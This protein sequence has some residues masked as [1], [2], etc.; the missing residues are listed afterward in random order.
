MLTAAARV[1]ETFPPEPTKP[2][3]SL[4]EKLLAVAAATEL[5]V[6]F[7]VFRMSRRS[8]AM[9]SGAADAV[10]SSFDVVAVEARPG[11]SR[12]SGD[13]DLFIYTKD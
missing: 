6:A 5:G 9:A 4:V 13:K 2:C 11:I 1:F 7:P 3:A 12:D 10:A 8:F